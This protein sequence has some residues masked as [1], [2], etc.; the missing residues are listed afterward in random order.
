MEECCLPSG[1][2]T[3]KLL[4]SSQMR[5]QMSH[6]GQH[7]FGLKAHFDG[8]VLK[9]PTYSKWWV[10]TDKA[11]SKLILTSSFPINIYIKEFMPSDK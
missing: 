10:V 2:Q 8:R 5:N 4:I 3:H 1:G 9:Y 11:F 7:S 6:R